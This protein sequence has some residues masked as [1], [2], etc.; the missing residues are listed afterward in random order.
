MWSFTD[1]SQTFAKAAE[2]FLLRD[3]VG[4]TIPLTVLTGV[5]AGM[6]ADG[7]YFAWWTVDGVVKGAA[8]R[9]PP[10]PLGLAV[11]PEEAAVSL[12]E[13]LADRDIPAVI[14]P[15]NVVDAFTTARGATI[16]HTVDERLYRLDGLRP[17]E[18]SGEG[19]PAVAADFPL[20]VNWVQAFG[21]EVAVGNGGDDV[22]GR[23]ERR[24]SGGDFCLWTDDG[25]PVAFA[26]MSAAAGGVSRIG[27]V[28]TPP[29]SRRRG[30]GAAV[31]AYTSQ[32]ALATR[33]DEVVLF[34]DLANP[35]S[36]AIYQQ[37]GYV[38]L[39]DYSHVTYVR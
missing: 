4:N 5:L 13:A 18:V 32:M 19:R 3:P 10:F 37:I 20:L 22:A 2:A 12:A 1:D 9:T 7:A 25:V 39:T 21:A 23:V 27:P 38:P 26:A 35:T 8:F 31:T 36:N 29:T 16:D 11:M 17:P 28:Y 24:L 34:T 15:V 30:Y 33:C 6:P 14:G